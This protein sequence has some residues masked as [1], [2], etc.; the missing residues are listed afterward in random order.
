MYAQ[1][2]HVHRLYALAGSNRAVPQVMVASMITLLTLIYLRFGRSE[3]W[4]E[5]EWEIS[6][7]G[8]DGRLSIHEFIHS[9]QRHLRSGPAT[10][11]EITRWFY[12]D[13]IIL[14][15]RLMATGKLPDNSFGF[16]QEGNRLRFYNLNNSLEFMV[17]RFNALSTMVYE[18]GLCG[19]LRQPDHPLTND[20]QRLLYEG[21]LSWTT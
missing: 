3:V 2:T 21:D 10:I 19:D 20:D 17:P 12:Q 13:Y 14:Q 18:L 9:L 11:G 4:Q 8:A 15:H 1:F 6:R 5:P 7:M 16:Q